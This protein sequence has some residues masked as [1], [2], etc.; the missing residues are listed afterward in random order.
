MDI[1]PISF[2]AKS[3]KKILAGEMN[4]TYRKARDASKPQ[5]KYYAPLLWVREPWTQPYNWNRFNP[6]YHAALHK[7]R[8]NDVWGQGYSFHWDDIP[9]DAWMPA[10]KM[11]KWACRILLQV[12]NRDLIMLNGEPTWRI[13]FVVIWHKYQTLGGRVI[14]G[15]RYPAKLPQWCKFDV[16]PTTI[17]PMALQPPP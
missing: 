10:G 1:L 8:P 11:P 5:Y 9:D 12:S 3:V 7:A 14:A 13:E 6:D 15:E 16:M 2:S 17:N 4:V